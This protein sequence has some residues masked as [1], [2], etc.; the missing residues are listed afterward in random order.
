MKSRKKIPSTRSSASKLAKG[1]R[2][3][4]AVHPVVMTSIIAAITIVTWIII[5][6]GWRLITG[7]K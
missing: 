6:Y 1:I 4:I 3:N 5:F 7:S 2:S